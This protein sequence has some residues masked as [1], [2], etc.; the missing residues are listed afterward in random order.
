MGLPSVW[1]AT[2]RATM[3]GDWGEDVATMESAADIR[4]PELGPIQLKN[5][6][7]G[8]VQGK[9]EQ[10]VVRP[11]VARLRCRDQ[12]RPPPASDT[13]IDHGEMHGTRR[14]KRGRAAKHILGAAHVLRGDLVA[15]INQADVRG[16][17]QDHA[18][19][20]SHVAIG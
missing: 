17:A 8:F 13:G 5:R 20:G 15:K 6:R 11:Y 18:F 9:R 4:Q 16:N 10:S 14:K 7:P 1:G 2:P 12:Q 3:R 19:H